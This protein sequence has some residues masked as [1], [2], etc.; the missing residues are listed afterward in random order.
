MEHSLQFFLLGFPNL[1]AIDPQLLSPHL[2][3]QH[4]LPEPLPLLLL[5]HGVPKQSQLGLLFIFMVPIRQ[6]LQ[7]Y[8]LD[9]QPILQ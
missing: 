3:L 4:E 2:E 5:V 1:Y 6:E 8:R 7:Q 9:F